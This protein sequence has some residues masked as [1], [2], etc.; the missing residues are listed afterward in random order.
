MAWYSV[1][2]YFTIRHSAMNGNFSSGWTGG[3]A[4]EST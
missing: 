1:Y 4:N 2:Y 3:G